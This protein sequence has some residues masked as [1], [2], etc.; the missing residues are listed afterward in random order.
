MFAVLF[1]L[2]QHVN[3]LSVVQANASGNFQ[4]YGRRFAAIPTEAVDFVGEGDVI[5]AEDVAWVDGNHAEQN[6]LAGRQRGQRPDDHH[7]QE[8]DLE[9]DAGGEDASL[10]RG[11][12]IDAKDE[13][14]RLNRFRIVRCLERR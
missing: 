1:G 11:Q 14:R 3:G 6:G 7:Q 5:A 8:Y 4:I 10:S 13:P 9:N 12:P 2:E